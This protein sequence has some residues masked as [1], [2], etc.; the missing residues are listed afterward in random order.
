MVRHLLAGCPECRKTTSR[1]WPGSAAVTTE[2][3]DL[4]DDDGETSDEGYDYSTVFARAQS[5]LNRH[6]MLLAEEQTAVPA[7]RQELTRHPRSRQEVLAS[8]SSR[9]HTWS[10]IDSL[11]DDCRPLC[12]ADPEEALHL[13][14]L[15]I[16]LSD[17]LNAERY[18]WERVTDLRARARAEL[19]NIRRVLGRYREAEQGFQRAR[20][21]LEQGT[22]DPLEEA[23]VASLEASLWIQRCEFERA[24]ALLD[25]AIVIARRM[26][27]NGLWARALIQKARC[28]TD[29]G[30]PE[31]ALSLLLE[32]QQHLDPTFDPRLAVTVQHN[33]LYALVQAGRFEEAAAGLPG[34]RALYRR[35][36]YPIDRIRLTWLEGRVCCG[37]ERLDEA[38]A[39][40]REALDGMLAE[41]LDYDAALVGLDLA[42]LYSQQNR[43]AEIRELAAAMLPV[44]S[45]HRIH[46]E[47][48]AALLVFRE[49]VDRERLSTE[50]AQNLAEY[51]RRAAVEPHLPF[52]PPPGLASGR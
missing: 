22:G 6:Q 43:N 41:G 20:D 34:T 46:R 5:E 4:P 14:T 33:I 10:L 29:R 23:G 30:L 15:A 12:Q 28:S 1:L 24:L 38:E 52:Q 49:A 32:A 18:G 50:L 26:G 27:E 45:S 2:A 8:N 44:F 39:R 19:A 35:F 42:V 47:A 37:L 9:F 11:L 3:R 25:S 36:D 31:D 51:L 13:V 40:F 7:L 48:L 17:L 16:R 21:L